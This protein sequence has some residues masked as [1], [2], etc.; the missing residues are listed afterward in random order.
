M[1]ATT[2]IIAVISPFIVALIRRRQ[3][4]REVIGL[5]SI[6]AVSCLYIVGCA[7][8]QS[9]SWPL[10]GE[11]WEGLLAALGTSGLTYEALRFVAPDALRK[12]ES[13]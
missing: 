6:F 2:F 11:F 5:F 12:M 7:F 9:L 1:T 10:G 3:W 13:V 4:S 8:D